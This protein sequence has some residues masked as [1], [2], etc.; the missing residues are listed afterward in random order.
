MHTRLLADLPHES[1][2]PF[3]TK[4]RVLNNGAAAVGL[5]SL[6]ALEHGGLGRRVIQDDVARVTETENLGGEYLKCN[7][8][9]VVPTDVSES[10]PG[11]SGSTR[12]R[13]FPCFLEGRSRRRIS[14]KG[15]RG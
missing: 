13:P 15:A 6:D 12:D 3:Q 7:I 8:G 14:W 10:I 11:S 1:G 2:A 5:E 9:S 4:G